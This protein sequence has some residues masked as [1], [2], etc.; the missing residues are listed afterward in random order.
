MGDALVDTNGFQP[1]VSEEALA[2]NAKKMGDAAK[3][4]M[5]ATGIHETP[6]FAELGQYLVT[7]P[8]IHYN[9]PDI[10][11]TV[12]LS[13]AKANVGAKERYIEKTIRDSGCSRK[14]AEDM[15]NFFAS[16]GPGPLGTWLFEE[17]NT[18]EIDKKHKLGQYVLPCSAN[19]LRRMKRRIK[20]SVR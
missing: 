20:I 3:I 13:H 19:T 6:A 2:E 8:I 5:F 17:G 1:A 16:G 10:N 7:H 14:N 12:I 4:L 11:G 9:Q 18:D 15:A